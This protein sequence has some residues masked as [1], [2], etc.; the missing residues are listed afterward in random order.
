MNL[1]TTTD[2]GSMHGEVAWPTVSYKTDGGIA[3]VRG[4]VPGIFSRSGLAWLERKAG[5]AY[6]YSSKGPIDRVN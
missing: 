4:K 2:S 6:S 1:E 5:R 3:F